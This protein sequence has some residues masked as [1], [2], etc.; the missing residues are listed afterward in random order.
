MLEQYRPIVIMTV[1]LSARGKPN[2]WKRE[3]PNTDPDQCGPWFNGS[4]VWKFVSFSSKK[5]PGQ[6]SIHMELIPTS[7]QIK[8][9]FQI[10]HWPI[11]VRENNK[12]LKVNSEKSLPFSKQRFPTRKVSADHKVNN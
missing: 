7:H 11:N 6:T 1:R 2:E 9:Q 3:G 4:S 5:V 10:K 8:D 12:A